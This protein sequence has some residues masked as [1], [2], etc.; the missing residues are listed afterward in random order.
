MARRR[1]D[2]IATRNRQVAEHLFLVRRVANHYAACTAERRDD[3]Q[4]VG[5]LG[6]IRAAERYDDRSAVPFAA[7]ARPHIRGAVL[8]YLRD[9][10]PL[11]RLSR[12]LQERAFQL[13]RQC[14]SAA[15]SQQASHDSRQGELE[16]LRCLQSVQL[17]PPWR[18]Q[19]VQANSTNCWANP[20]VDQIEDASQQIESETVLAALSQL[21]RRQRQV[22]EAVVL[23]GQTLRTVA[24]R[25][26]ISA[27]TVH[28]VLHQAL[29]ELRRQLSP[30]S[31]APGC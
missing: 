15:V 6:L 7:F 13:S 29:A 26:G 3:L 19:E 22:V 18:L 30:A 23:Q 17:L 21:E 11:L 4:Q 16:S 20:P 28:R 31:G 27:A 1:T 24:G 2:P 25:I 14:G 8:H 12:R 5:A 10:A 9:V